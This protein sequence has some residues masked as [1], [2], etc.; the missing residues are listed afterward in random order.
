MSIIRPGKLVLSLLLASL[1][2]APQLPAA[3]KS[4]QEK[5][6]Q[7]ILNKIEKLKKSIDVKEDSKSKY[8]TQLKSIDHIIT[9]ANTKNQIIVIERT[10]TPGYHGHGM[11]AFR[12]RAGYRR[13]YIHA[14]QQD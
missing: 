8:I 14:Y 12:K 4:S 10:A 5:K 9:V 1:V 3:D 11:G 6:L 2:T 13:R 7:T